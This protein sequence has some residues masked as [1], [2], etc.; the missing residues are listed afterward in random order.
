MY[1]NNFLEL[2]IVSLVANLQ[3]KKRNIPTPAHIKLTAIMNMPAA[4]LSKMQKMIPDTMPPM[5]HPIQATKLAHND[6][7]IAHNE[8]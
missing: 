7:I 4:I 2:I 1:A 3:R 8:I 5:L 6:K